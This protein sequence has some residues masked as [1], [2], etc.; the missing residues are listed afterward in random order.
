MD[1][2]LR[3]TTGS[4]VPAENEAMI[5]RFLAETRPPRAKTPVS[6]LLKRAELDDS[7]AS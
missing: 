2:F 7:Q 3:K 5:A 1:V 6:Y 4:P